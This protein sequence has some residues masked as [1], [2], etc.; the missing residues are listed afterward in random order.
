MKNKKMEEVRETVMQEASNGFMAPMRALEDDTYLAAK[1]WGDDYQEAI[2]EVYR[3][4]FRRVQASGH[5]L[6]M[7]RARTLYAMVHIYGYK[8][9]RA[10]HILDA[11][12]GFDCHPTDRLLPDGDYRFEWV[13]QINDDINEICISLY[14]MTT[15]EDNLAMEEA[16]GDWRSIDWNDRID[17]YEIFEL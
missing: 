9:Q 11:L 4:I 17:G 3:E 14:Y 13:S 5:R 8:P 12:D 10:A 15:P 7:T 1:G 16:G 6:R 2:E